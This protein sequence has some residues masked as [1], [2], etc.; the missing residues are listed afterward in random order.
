M[1]VLS[2]SSPPKSKA[3][4]VSSRKVRE[5]FTGYLFILP[6]FLVIGIFGL[7]PIAYAVYMSLFRWR[8]R[9]G[10]FIGFDNYQQLLGNPWG[11]LV[12][13]GGL[14]LILLA[15]WL[16]TDAFKVNKSFRIG[17]LLGAIVLI[18][19]GVFMSLGWT[20]ML[21]EGSRDTNDFL[22]AL[23]RTVF[24]AFGSIPL[25][26]VFSLLL[27]SLLYQKIRGQELFRMIFFLPYV[28]PVV[29]TSV[30]FRSIFS[31]REESIANQVIT[32]L[33]LPAQRWLFESKPI[34]QVML[35]ERLTQFNSWLSQIGVSWQLEGL[36]LGPSL[37][38]IVLIFFGIWTYS[39]YN[40]VIFLAGLGNI[41]KQLYEAAEIDGANGVQK[42]WNITVPLLSPVTFY[43]TVLGFI[44]AL[45]AFT[46]LYVMRQPFA[47]DSIDT[48]S[49]LIFDTFYKSN[50]FS[51]AATQS[52][53]LFVLILAVTLLQNRI[54][55]RRV[56]DA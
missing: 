37:A 36:W 38:L 39:G 53:V 51:L 20:T 28:M 17:R 18:A 44:G 27:A 41:P 4:A 1:A 50:N 16:W 23:V 22:N 45:Q 9:K 42:F 35:G 54:L 6:A 56:F 21:T 3:K 11:A 40:V 30:V 34:L 19:A 24:Y 2:S 43:L 55:G 52:I 29:A 13:L 25:Q 49:V 31:Q 47:R 46:Q 26:I 12:F 32:A 15:H 33:G 8:V 10:S 5:W 48:A 7:F 14:L